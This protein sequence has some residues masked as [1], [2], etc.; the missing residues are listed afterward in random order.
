MKR[1][2]SEVLS[3]EESHP[4][5]EVDRSSHG[6]DA[7]NNISSHHS[8][9]NLAMVREPKQADAEDLSN[10]TTSDSTQVDILN[11][12]AKSNSPPPHSAMSPIHIPSQGANSALNGNGV[13][14]NQ[15]SAVS[16]RV[17]TV[18]DEVK[19]DINTNKTHT[20]KTDIT[21]ISIVH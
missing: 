16:P 8:E 5:M 21:F 2:I 17:S 14:H 9:E 18:I 10:T 6:T 20:N 7:P 19:T 12:Q 11:H 15:S 1:S 4:N 13:V 3:T